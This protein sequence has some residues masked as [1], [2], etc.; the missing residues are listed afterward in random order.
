MKQG[1]WSA[2]ESEPFF[3]SVSTT[4]ATNNIDLVEYFFDEDPG[5]GAGTLLPQTPSTNLDFTEMVD[6][7]SLGAGFHTIYFRVRDEVGQWSAT[8]SEPFFITVSSSQVRT[9]I[10]NMEYYFNIDPGFG[11]DR[12]YLPEMTLIKSPITPT[13]VPSLPMISTPLP[14]LPRST[15]PVTSRPIMLPV[16]VLLSAPLI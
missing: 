9:T 15:L 4:E 16:T 8:E 14:R 12:A 7:S 5:F 1:Q 3:I 11:T 13:W 2:T 10:T 6:V